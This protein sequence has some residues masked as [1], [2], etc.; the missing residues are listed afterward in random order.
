[1]RR[2]AELPAQQKRVLQALARVQFATHGQLARL[3]EAQPSHTSTA[4]KALLDVGLIDGTLT[5]RPAILHLTSAGARLVGVVMPAGRRH[6]SWSVM[7]HAC[8]LT[9]AAEQL[10]ATHPGFRFLPRLDLIRQGFNPGHGEHG[11]TD[12]SGAAWF[13]LL[14]DYQMGSDR[15]ARAWTRRHSPNPKHW[16]D[17]TGK[18]WREVVQ[19]FLVICTDPDQAERHQAA[20]TADHLPADLLLTRALW[21]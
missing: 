7:A 14:D 3:T 6:A 21:K 16:P 20:I 13:V 9:E 4:I 10:A 19:R 5:T 12:D 2:A 17:P 1:M 11:A 18:T 15:I 8:H